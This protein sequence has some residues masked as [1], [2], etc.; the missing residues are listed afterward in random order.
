[1]MVVVSVP[2]PTVLPPNDIASD[3]FRPCNL[4]RFL[5]IW[6]QLVQPFDKAQTTCLGQLVLSHEY[7]SFLLVDQQRLL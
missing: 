4:R 7:V 1:M 2:A 5:P 3:A 6:L